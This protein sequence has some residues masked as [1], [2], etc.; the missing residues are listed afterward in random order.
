[1]TTITKQAFN[2]LRGEAF[3]VQFE[4]IPNA[5]L[6]DVRTPMEHMSGNIP[7]SINIDIMDYDFHAKIA[8]LD[9]DKIYFLYCRSGNRSSQ[10]C[11]I[12]NDMGFTTVNL[13]GGIGA[14]PH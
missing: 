7:N 2:E 4:Q 5:E 14:W 12:M 1:M 6:L 8:E 11:M 3:K 9:K 13:A 10:A